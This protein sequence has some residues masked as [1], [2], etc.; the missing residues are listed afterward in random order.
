MAAAAVR[1]WPPAGRP[2]RPGLQPVG[3][4]GGARALV[5]GGGRERRDAAWPALHGQVRRRHTRLHTAAL[6]ALL[7]AVRARALA[8]EGSRWAAF[9]HRSCRR[10]VGFC[11]PRLAFSKLNGYSNPAGIWLYE[12]QGRLVMNQSS[13]NPAGVPFGQP[14]AVRANVSATIVGGDHSAS[15][16]EFA[17]DGMP[18]DCRWNLLRCVFQRCKR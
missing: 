12:S 18:H 11:D 7:R 13:G 16:L 3:Q 8:R 10:S 17:L 5:L 4:H 9:S 1:P 6:A 2:Q 15:V 14:W